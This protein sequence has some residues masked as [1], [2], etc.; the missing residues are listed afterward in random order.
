MC[1]QSKL[2]CLIFSILCASGLNAAQIIGR[3]IEYGKPIRNAKVS[4]LQTNNNTL[5]NDKGRFSLTGVEL[6][7]Y[8]LQISLEGY[9]TKE[10]KI[11]VDKEIVDL[12]DITI[13]DDFLLLNQLVVTATRNEVLRKDAP[14]VCNL[15]DDRIL[16][17]T[18]SVTLSEGLN[19]QPA[20]RMEDN[21]QNCGFNSLRM[22]GLE[23]AYSQILI[24][25]R[26]I[27]NSLQGVYG[28]E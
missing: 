21:C 25:G 10:I 20:L 24:D 16:H 9:Q 12:G 27:Y 18:Q 11:N 19:F 7:K 1:K 3:V 26:P 22:N 17:A 6:G 28:L 5:T 15:L 14:I 8:T 4:L 13:K 2:L 23:G